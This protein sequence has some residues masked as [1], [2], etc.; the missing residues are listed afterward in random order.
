MDGST[1][2]DHARDWR[3]ARRLAIRGREDD[4]GGRAGGGQTIADNPLLL[5]Q[6]CD[7]RAGGGQAAVHQVGSTVVLRMRLLF[8]PKQ[9]VTYLS[10]CTWL[11]NAGDFNIGVSR[12]SF[13][14]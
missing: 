1:Q 2:E 3:R 10:T 5:L 4:D 13:C 8:L 12:S 11:R 6:R 7:Q 14:Q 9:F